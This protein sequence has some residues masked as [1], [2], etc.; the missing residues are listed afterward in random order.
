MSSKLIAMIR[1][2][3]RQHLDGY[4]F[5]VA[6]LQLVAMAAAKTLTGSIP[7]STVLLG[8]QLMPA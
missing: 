4:V 3:D 2:K 1:D 5:V 6:H 7:T 8:S